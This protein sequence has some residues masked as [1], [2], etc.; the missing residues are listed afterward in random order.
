MAKSDFADRMWAEALATLDRAE[1]LQRQFFQPA[2]AA[3]GG[4]CWAPPTD[5]FE[6]ASEFIVL[7]ALPG[8]AADR[9]GVHFDAPVL[10]VSGDRRFP[11]ALGGTSIRRL[12]I[13]QGRF[14]RRLQIEA[15]K[16]LRTSLDDGCLTL[17]LAK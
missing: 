14:E 8:V 9:I 3:R 5:V 6:G 17:V 13:P 16:L 10:T 4:T 12:E 1:R 2:V 7:I 11:A 15:R